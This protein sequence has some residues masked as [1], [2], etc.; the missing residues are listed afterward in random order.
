VDLIGRKKSS[1]ESFDHYVTDVCERVKRCALDKVTNVMDWFTTMIVVANHDNVKV[2]KKLLLEKDLKLDTAKAICKEE[3]KAAKMSCRLGASRTS[4]EAGASQAQAGESASGVSSY[5]SSRGRGQQRGRGA[6]RG[7]RGGFHHQ[8]DRGRSPSRERSESRDRSG[9]RER[10]RGNCY[11]CGNSH[12]GT[13]PAINQV[14]N[15]CQKVG[16]YARA[17][18][19]GKLFT[20]SSS[21]TA[22]VAKQNETALVAKQIEVV[23]MANRSGSSTSGAPGSAKIFSIHN[24]EKLELVQV[25]IEIRDGSRRQIEA[26]PDTGANITAFQ[27]EILPKL[28]LSNKDM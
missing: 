12:Q 27:P 5:Q 26:L 9:S 23:P 22:P 24:P 17:C 2:R 4:G 10:S 8:Q 28:G 16:Y 11:R 13:C 21:I 6:P 19:A 18:R 15:N 20:S 3:E 1:N 25:E 7:G 14:C